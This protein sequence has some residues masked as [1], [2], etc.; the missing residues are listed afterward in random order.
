MSNVS[1]GGLVDF[2]FLLIVTFSNRMESRGRTKGESGVLSEKNFKVFCKEGSVKDGEVTRLCGGVPKVEW[3]KVTRGG[4]SESV[5][6][7]EGETPSGRS[8]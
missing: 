3:P 1:E 7:G 8:V 5:K 2:F 4:K 6:R